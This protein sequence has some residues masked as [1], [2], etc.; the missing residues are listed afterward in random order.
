MKPW[1]DWRRV[2]RVSMGK[3][4]MST[5]VPAIPPATRAVGKGVWRSSDA[6]VHRSYQ[7][8]E[9]LLILTALLGTWSWAAGLQPSLLVYTLFVCLASVCCPPSPITNQHFQ[10]TPTAPC[11]MEIRFVDTYRPY[12]NE[13]LALLSTIVCNNI[14]LS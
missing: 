2:F 4:A 9:D 1:G 14:Q 5:V 8:E 11:T 13:S 10:R 3:R 6:M 12:L 7:E